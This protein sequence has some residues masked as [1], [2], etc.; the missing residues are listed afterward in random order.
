MFCSFVDSGNLDVSQGISGFF[1]CCYC[2]VTQSCLTLCD[3]MDCVASPPGSSVHGILEAKN[4]GVGCHS[5]LQGIFLG[6]GSNLGLLHCRQ[7][8]YH[9]GPSGRFARP[10]G[11]GASRG[12]GEGE[13][14]RQAP[15][16]WG[17]SVPGGASG[18]L[19]QDGRVHFQLADTLSLRTRPRSAAGPWEC[20]G[21][22]S[23][24]GQAELPPWKRAMLA[25]GAPSEPGTA[26]SPP[27]C[28]VTPTAPPGRGR[29]FPPLQVRKQQTR[30][31][32]FRPGSCGRS[33]AK[34]GSYFG[35]LTCSAPSAS[36]PG[37]A[38]VMLVALVAKPALD[39]VLKPVN[40]STLLSPSLKSSLVAQLVKNPPAR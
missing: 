22:S 17:P 2:S 8:L 29:P 24:Q 15:P 6:Q 34:L 30:A 39:V 10:L 11:I 27:G 31:V 33:V 35:A 40:S 25:A 37:G 3:P 12:M 20:G 21:R 28:L 23:G 16:R 38:F 5:P 9:G 7:T 4:I 18:A 26:P 19:S 14:R 13:E 36:S 1:Q 32:A